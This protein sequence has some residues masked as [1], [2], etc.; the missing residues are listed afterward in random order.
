M[1]YRE[2]PEPFVIA[3]QSPG[4]R[5]RQP[6][7][8]R[9]AV[10]VEA[11]EEVCEL[12]RGVYPLAACQ[13]MALRPGCGFKHGWREDHPGKVAHLGVAQ[14]AGQVDKAGK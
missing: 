3:A 10:T 14:L 13:W 1:L 5:Q 7:F 12:F 6:V 4:C 2:L 11:P 8:Q 9:A